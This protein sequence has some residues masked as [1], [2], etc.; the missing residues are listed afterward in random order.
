LLH[1][2]LSAAEISFVAR[3]IVCYTFP[4]WFF[5]R[6]WTR[7]SFAV[8]CQYCENFQILTCLWK[9]PVDIN[10]G[11]SVFFCLTCCITPDS[12]WWLVSFQDATYV[13]FL[14]VFLCLFMLY[15]V[16]LWCYCGDWLFSAF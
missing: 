4:R 12:S 15:F 6:V 1:L 7:I 9:H 14:W 8:N 13:G 11:S 16:A 2:Y 10:M 5:F 3:P